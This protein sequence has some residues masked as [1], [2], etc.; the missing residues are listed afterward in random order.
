MKLMESMVLDRNYPTELLKA[1]NELRS[2]VI[3]LKELD[4]PI[5]LHN[6][7]EVGGVY[8]NIKIL[9]PSEKPF[10]K[11][12]CR[13]ESLAGEKHPVT[14][15]LFEQK[16]IETRELRIEVVVPQFEHDF[17]TT[18]PEKMHEGTDREQF[19]YCNEKLKEACELNPDLREKFTPEQMEQIENSDRPDGYVW[20]HA[21]NPGEMQLINKEDHD[22]TGH[23]GG[24][25]IWGGGSD[26]R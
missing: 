6:K 9:E 18:L 26:N 25:A 19:K 14:G 10:I 16:I 24:K 3:S 2:E 13:N 5:A 22:Q 8:E 15:V 7:A 23:T 4:K 11:I 17:K 20:H 1:A 12:I 21:E